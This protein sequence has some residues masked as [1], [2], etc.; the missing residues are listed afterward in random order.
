M[1]FPLGPARVT[2]IIDFIFKRL[3]GK[4]IMAVGAGSADMPL[5]PM[6]DDNA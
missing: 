5:F 1:N 4:D 2:F 6:F 3:L